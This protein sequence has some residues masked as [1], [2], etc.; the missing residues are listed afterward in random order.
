MTIQESILKVSLA[1]KNVTGSL[2]SPHDAPFVNRVLAGGGDDYYY[3]YV[4]GI[5]LRNFYAYSNSAFD[6][7]NFWSEIQDVLGTGMPKPSNLSADTR[8][9]QIAV[10]FAQ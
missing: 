4:G 9:V 5:P 3:H 2:G 6:D 1:L 8:I 10:L 7:S